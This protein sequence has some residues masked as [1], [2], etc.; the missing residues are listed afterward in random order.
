M[1]KKIEKESHTIDLSLPHTE[2][3]VLTEFTTVSNVP[4]S[5]PAEQ[6]TFTT[7]ASATYYY[8]ILELD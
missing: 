3:I 6:S 4:C 2:T 5:L 1:L 8:F 7:L